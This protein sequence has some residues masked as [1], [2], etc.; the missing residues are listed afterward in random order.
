MRCRVLLLLLV[1]AVVTPF[2]CRDSARSALPSPGTNVTLVI[3]DVTVIDISAVS[4]A[5]AHRPHHTVALE[6]S[7]IAVVG[8]TSSFQIPE[9]ARV[10]S[11]QGLYL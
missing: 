7:R 8:P 9:G 4:T 10:V 5:L 1:L 2:G 6:G 3:S 11:G